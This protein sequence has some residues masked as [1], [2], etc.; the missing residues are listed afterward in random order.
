MKL[1]K[2]LNIKLDNVIIN[3][4]NVNDYVPVDEYNSK[5]EELNIT[6]EDLIKTETELSKS[7]LELDSTKEILIEKESELN[8]T[9]SE[10]SETQSELSD[11][12]IELDNTKE[13]LSSTKEELDDT[14][15][16][17]VEANTKIE[18]LKGLSID[19]SE[20]GYSE[21]P[22][23]IDDGFEYAKI[24][25]SNA[26]YYNNNTTF[27]NDMQLTYFP[28]IDWSDISMFNYKFANCSRLQYVGKINGNKMNPNFTYTFQNCPALHTIELIEL[29]YAVINFTTFNGTDYLTNLTCTNLGKIFQS[30]TFQFGNLQYWSYQTMIDS[31]L[32]YSYDR[33]NETDIIT[34]ELHADAKAKLTD[35]DI[36][37]ITLKGYTIV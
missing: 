20:L 11:T 15:T 10:L 30:T 25:V 24:I 37:A 4:I 12:K 36:A 19:W 26:P 28:T 3:N 23:L 31:L 8:S 5:V 22:S 21:R 14:K 2:K 16:E 29:D 9:K 17:L 13:T 33:S 32:N 34:I 7:Q 1:E 35:T 27:E 18:E 6:K